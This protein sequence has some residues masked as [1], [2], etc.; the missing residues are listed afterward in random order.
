MRTKNYLLVLLYFAL[1][2]SCSKIQNDSN[3][4][5]DKKLSENSIFNLQTVWNTQDSSQIKLRD[6]QGKVLV[7]VMIYTSCK[8]ACPR[9]VAD[10][11]DI[12]SQIPK[13]YLND[14]TFVLISI[15]PKTD[16][17]GRLKR[18]AKANKMDASHWIFLQGTESD[19]REFA[20]V[21][22][23]KYKEISPLDF[24]HSNIISVIDRSGEMVFQQEGLGVNNKET[25]NKIIETVKN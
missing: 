17:P 24:S 14:L 6:L 9:L 20:N 3:T 18:F 8:A 11:R 5:I 25:I 12:E 15:D 7:M 10:M 19:T 1:V 13:N 2:C 16:K 22:A 21:M 23:V 4:N